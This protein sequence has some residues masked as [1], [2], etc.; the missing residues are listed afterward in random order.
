MGE[1]L[2]NSYF[3]NSIAQPT[4]SLST[5]TYVGTLCY[6][7]PE[8]LDGSFYSFPSD[9]WAL[10]IIIYE[11]V[12]GKNPYP[13]TDKPIILNEMMRKEQAPHLD[14]FASLSEDLK[15]F[16]KRCLQKDP[17]ERQSA[18]DLLTHQFIQMH[19]K[20]EES[21]LY[22]NWLAQYKEQRENLKSKNRQIQINLEDYELNDLVGLHQM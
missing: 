13:P 17:N 7:S 12:T 21:D 8:R 11:M 9:I 5:Q 14:R 4:T 6:M 10:G 2:T 3:V 20:F 19:N 16:I 22:I 15:D 18:A 1:S